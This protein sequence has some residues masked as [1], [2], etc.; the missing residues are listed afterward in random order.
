MT[1]KN[2]AV[3][4]LLVL[5]SP[6]L[7]A[8]TEA[9]R[10]LKQDIDRREQ[11]LRER[12]WDDLRAPAVPATWKTTVER[13]PDRRHRDRRVDHADQCAGLACGFFPSGSA[14]GV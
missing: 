14:L 1:L 12:R 11:E 9:E 13:Q 6:S 10:L 2:W 5:A 3:A 8:A 7:P 4:G